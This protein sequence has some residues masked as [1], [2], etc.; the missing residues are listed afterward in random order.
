MKISSKKLF[1]YFY[2]RVGFDGAERIL[3]PVEIHEKSKDMV[4]E[5]RSVTDSFSF[6]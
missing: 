3:G 6:T 2:L 1:L 5:D 4:R